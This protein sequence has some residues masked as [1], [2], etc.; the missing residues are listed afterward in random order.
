MPH[1]PD[2]RFSYRALLAQPGALAFT[3]PNLV[4]RLPMGMFSVAA[5]IMITAHHGS[6]ALA[7]AVQAT[8]LIGSVLAGPLIARQV[9]R[10][11]QARVLVPAVT[12]CVA[13]HT[14]LLLCVLLGAPVWSWFCCVLL[15]AATPNTGGMSRARW[16]HLFGEPTPE[17][18]AARHTANAFEQALDELCF[19][20]GPVLAAFLC[21]ALFP[22]AG[23]VT[24]A[25][26][27]L[28]G[29]LLFAAQRRTEPPPVPPRAGG[30]PGPL[31]APG[32]PM[33]LAAFV[34]AGA[35]FGSLE[36]V[37]I[38]FAD[39]RGQ[40]GWAGP[41]LAAQAAGSA[42]AGLLFGALR[43][44]GSAPGRFAACAAAM[45]ALMTL[46]PLVA[47]VGSL[48]LLAPA[49]LLAGMAT[50]P[51][52]VTGMTLVQGVVPPG[53]LNEG[54][55][56]A[57]TALLGGIALGAASGGWAVDHLSGGATTAYW[58]PVSAALLAAAFAT[59]GRYRPFRKAAATGPASR[60]PE[61]PSSSITAKAT[62]RSPR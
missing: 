11:G 42:A 37:T 29:T 4:A 48:P 14:A 3:V 25:A 18:A 13:G 1:S 45:A 50:A 20:C 61:P 6:Y 33:L 12:V 62:S 47:Q 34:C 35:I 55:T 23:T 16:A 27:M 21:T 10:R 53:R 41:V 60:P 19:M 56:L 39:E 40:Q 24:A 54:M 46:P 2:A 52:M 32:M 36:V 17:H 58:A 26:L 38:A 7:G 49:L 31:R 59:A 28:G 51:T 9:D 5:V 15:T 57:V 8:G 43:V 22:A 30:G 44:G